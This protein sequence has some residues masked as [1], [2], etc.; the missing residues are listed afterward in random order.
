MNTQNHW[1]ALYLVGKYPGLPYTPDKLLFIDSLQTISPKDF[2]DEK[3]KMF[4]L[5]G[6]ID[7]YEFYLSYLNKLQRDFPE[8]FNQFLRIVSIPDTIINISEK[9]FSHFTFL[10][11]FSALQNI[12]ETT[13]KGK[14][15]EDFLKKMFNAIDGLEVLEIKQSPDEQIDLIIKNNINRPFWIYLNNPIFI[16]EAKNWTDK[17]PTSVLNTLRGK[18]DG[19]SNFSHI[20]FVIALNG[21]TE[22]I[23]NN[24]VRDGGGKKIIVPING[25]DIGALL[26]RKLD[27][28]DWLEN[29]ITDAF[30]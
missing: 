17:T 1:I 28:I 18:M 29:K 22:R 13:K 5:F 8:N 26:R 10:E 4:G 20:G 23:E 3:I 21:F 6:Q 7:E 25:D 12:T 9:I 30:K 11:E 27:P 14:A 19:H 16:G 2:S 15:F 24:I